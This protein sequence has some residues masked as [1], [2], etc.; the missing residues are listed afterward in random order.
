MEGMNYMKKFI[1]FFTLIFCL[2]AADDAMLLGQWDSFTHGVN[3]GT[4]TIEKEY[5]KFYDNY[6][7][8][9]LFLVTV[10]KGNAFVKDLRIE[11]TGIWKTRGNILVVVVKDVEVPVAGE[12]Y[13]ISQASLE[14]IAA[15]FHN[16]FKNDPIR[17]LV[18]KELSQHTLVTENKRKELATYKRQQ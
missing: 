14:E 7:F 18:I 16:R 8:D 17:I 2:N 9:I 3:N 11:G 15:T 13:G 4:K 5:L 1:L 10:Q 6:T 12:V